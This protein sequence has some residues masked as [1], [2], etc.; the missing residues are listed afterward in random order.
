MQMQ[1]IA[2]KVQKIILFT[3]DQTWLRNDE[4]S[5]NILI[6]KKIFPLIS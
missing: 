6:P 2:Q 5:N 1:K 4:E 3:N